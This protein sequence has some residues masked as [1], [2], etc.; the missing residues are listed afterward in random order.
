MLLDILMMMMKIMIPRKISHLH[1]L[2]LLWLEIGERRG[3]GGGGDLEVKVFCFRVPSDMIILSPVSPQKWR[4]LTWWWA[5]GTS[6]SRLAGWSLSCLHQRTPWTWGKKVV[7]VIFL[8]DHF[9]I[10]WSISELFNCM[11][12]KN[13]AWL[14]VGSRKRSLC[15]TWAWAIRNVSMLFLIKM[16]WATFEILVGCLLVMINVRKRRKWQLF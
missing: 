9:R 5:A 12:T 13:L 3:C 14:A 16:S 1:W 4:A 6:Q 10:A 15:C 8:H 2:R 11:R 7:R